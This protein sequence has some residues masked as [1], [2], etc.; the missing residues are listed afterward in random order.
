M[1]TV[2]GSTTDPGTA[3]VSGDSEQWNGVLGVS[4]GVGQAGVAGVNE[5]AG[6][7]VYGRGTG[8]GVWG[9]GMSGVDAVGVVGISDQNDGVRGFSSTPGKSGT[10]GVHTGE[11]GSGLWG[12]ADNG[13]GVSGFSKI[14]SGVYGRSEG[15]EGVRGESL[16]ANHGG[17]VGV[18][19]AVGG[20]GVYGTCDNGIGV[21][22]KGGQLAGR[23]EGDVEVTG[24]LTLQG[25]SILPRIVAVEQQ[26]ASLPTQQTV[27]QLQQQ[28]TALQNQLNTAVSN[29]QGRVT[30]AEVAIS[31]LKAR[32]E[33][34]GG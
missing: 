8:N 7:G 32:V 28:V 19:L 25:V 34:L 3:G 12:S 9:H 31:D 16:N 13:R 4:R 26:V 22:G 23:F 14:S 15:N 2:V 27:T 6:N 17:V 33:R 1:S 10:V 30:L 29:L 18:S 20:H 11:N 5:S 21:I 24:N